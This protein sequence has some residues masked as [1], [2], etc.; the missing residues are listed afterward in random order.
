M[1][2]LDLFLVYLEIG[3][4]SFGG[5]Y[6]AMPLIQTLVV[7]QKGWLTMA[8][9]ADLTTIAEMTPGPIAVNSATF[10]GQKMA[11]LPGALICTLGCILPSV[12]IVLLL[13][14]L[15]T[16]FRNLKIV[17]NV[18]GE[19]R[20]A[21]VAMIAGAGLT[22][23]LLAFFGTSSLAEISFG[24]IRWIEVGLYIVSLI[25]IRKYK[26]GPIAIIF[27]TA[28]VGTLLYCL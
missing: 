27:S 12:L 4:F 25:L 18:L 22:I 14:W 1:I 26:W 13:A 16:K 11:G 10:V 3:A 20:P 15:Y 17:K 8:E 9:Y 28:A 23:I 7:Q 5:G 24:S 19:L 6:A 21:V 2:L